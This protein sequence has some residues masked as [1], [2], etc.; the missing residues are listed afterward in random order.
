MRS[1]H[2]VI[3]ALVVLF[4]SACDHNKEPVLGSSAG[5]EVREPVPLEEFAPG[6]DLLGGDSD[7]EGGEE[8]P[9]DERYEYDVEAG[10]PIC[11][12]EFCTC[13]ERA[14]DPDPDDPF[15]CSPG[16]G[17]GGDICGWHEGDMMA[18][19]RSFS[20]SICAGLSSTSGWGCS[21]RDGMPGCEKFKRNSCTVVGGRFE[22]G[23]GRY[24][25]CAQ[26]IYLQCVP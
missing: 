15:I 25:E 17:A 12:E 7:E 4:V 18:A 26:G 14:G 24:T 9:Y 3:S 19:R 6:S 16:A 21:Y 2:F 1:I 10:Y 20:L 8:R 11:E 22:K 23:N 13:Y 5:P